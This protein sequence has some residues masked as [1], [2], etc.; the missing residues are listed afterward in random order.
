[1]HQNTNDLYLIS[2]A[3][4]IENSEV[5]C[6]KFMLCILNMDIYT[7]CHIIVA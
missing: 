6:T 7:V 2:L 5:Y 3:Y 1:M 4:M